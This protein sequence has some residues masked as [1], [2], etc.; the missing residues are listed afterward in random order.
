MTIKKSGLANREI[1]ALLGISPQ[2]A[3]IWRASSESTLTKGQL[4]YA[5]ILRA[6]KLFELSEVETE[7]LANKA[8]LSLQYRNLG[9]MIADSKFK[10]EIAEEITPYIVTGEHNTKRTSPEPKTLDYIEFIHHTN[11]VS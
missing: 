4:K 8:G 10:F 6:G 1:Y 11:A 9:N 3:T 5:T 2:H 7:S